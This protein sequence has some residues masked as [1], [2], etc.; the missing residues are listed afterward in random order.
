MSFIFNRKKS[1]RADEPLP[2]LGVSPASPPV[3]PSPSAKDIASKNTKKSKT[4]PVQ[5][6]TRTGGGG[7]AYPSY[8]ATVDEFGRPKEAGGRKSL[9]GLEDEELQLMFGYWPIEAERELDLVKVEDIIRKCGQQIKSRGLD[10]PLIFSTRALD[11]S[12]DA[13]CSLIR[14][15]LQDPSAWYRDIQFSSPLS[16]ASMIKWSLGR[17]YNPT[18]GHGFLAWD[19]YERWRIGERE[20]IY[21]PRYFTTH[22]LY[23]LSTQTS[24]LLQC[25]MELLSST[26]AYSHQNG[27]TP[28]KLASLFSAYIFGLPDDETFDTTYSVWLKYT[29]ATE[30]MLL[31]YIRDQKATTN[32]HIPARL[33][34]FIKTYDQSIQ[35]NLTKPTA[36]ARLVEVKRIKRLARF[37]SKN[38]ILGAGQWEVTGSKSWNLLF[39]STKPA[40]V[41]SSTTLVPP[42]PAYTSAYRHLLNI[43]NIDMTDVDVVKGDLQ[44][45]KSLVEKEWSSFTNM[46]FGDGLVEEKKL[47]FDLTESERTG[48]KTKHDTMDWG[49]FASS[50]F[51]GRETYLQMDLDFSSSV[52]QQVTSWPERRAELSQQLRKTEKQ[53]PAFPYNV[54]PVEER[55]IML[56]DTFFEAWADVLISSGWTRDENKESSWGL[57]QWKS[58]P[59]GSSSQPLDGDGRTEERW[60]LIE[61]TVPSEYRQEII[62]RKSKEKSGKRLSFLR[63]VRRKK[64]KPLPMPAIKESISAPGLSKYNTMPVSSSSANRPGSAAG[65]NR[66]IDQSVFSPSYTGPTRKLSAG[67]DALTDLSP[68]ADFAHS[69]AASIGGS[70]L[71][72]AGHGGGDDP[73]PPPP[74]PPNAP[75]MGRGIGGTL[76]SQRSSKWDRHGGMPFGRGKQLSPYNQQMPTGSFEYD[77]REASSFDEM[78]GQNGHGR[79]QSKDDTWLDIMTSSKSRM[80]AQEYDPTA[81]R[82]DSVL[83]E[84]DEEPE[85][86]TPRASPTR[87][88]RPTPP[89]LSV[90]PPT[91]VSEIVTDE[92]YVPS[93]PTTQYATE[94]QSSVADDDEDPYGG[95]SDAG[96]EPARSPVSPTRNEELV[97]RGVRAL[98]ASPSEVDP[99]RHDRNGARPA[100]GMR[101]NSDRTE[102]DVPIDYGDDPMRRSK[103]SSGGAGPSTAGP[104]RISNLIGMYEDRDAA[105]AQSI[106]PAVAGETKTVRLSDFGFRGT[107][108]SS[109]VGQNFQGQ[110]KV[111]RVVRKL[112]SIPGPRE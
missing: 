97:Y 9:S 74:P 57:I 75:F 94:G 21:P 106:P 83:S 19:M 65:N 109:P 39:P 12:V 87:V 66:A 6:T 84:E 4:L 103:F 92:S 80:T 5:P 15:Y 24:N 51:S 85:T 30:H 36:T 31:A 17:I 16:L 108:T 38:I 3:P 88:F 104:S 101:R 32:V 81:K 105:A 35:V 33:E 29:H 40:A 37:H 78:V 42:T 22:L 61:E 110:S 53:L 62:E 41:S 100:L 112:P 23:H 77:E 7:A 89:I 34:E 73:R 56:D 68:G 82:R 58:R 111:P 52:K 43:R 70:T 79:S 72:T 90:R 63:A 48:R 13:N 98:P 49:T 107:G 99:Y 69:S 71:N 86:T 76:S 47:Q 14:A 20:K 91:V 25:L 59:E 26:A 27:M 55:P 54:Q 96:T 64:D 8:G 11:I 60:F 95:M 93:R 102:P 44:R 10:T 18:G 50:G 28:K 67:G 2:N 45:Y 1:L 46:G